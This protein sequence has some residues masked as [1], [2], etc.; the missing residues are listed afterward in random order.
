[1]R[2]DYISHL[3]LLYLPFY[4]FIPFIFFLYISI[5]L[6][7]SII[8]YYYSKNELPLPDGFYVTGSRTLLFCWHKLLGFL[9]LV[10]II[11]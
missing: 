2:W 9:L 3:Y 8:I 5:T 7:I 10:I 4:I 11:L 1:M 6:F